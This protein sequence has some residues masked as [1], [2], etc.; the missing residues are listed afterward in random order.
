MKYNPGD[1]YETWLERVRTAELEWA[2]REILR[3]KDVDHVLEQMSQRIVNK[4][5]HPLLAI[6]R[7]PKIVDTGL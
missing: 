2:R 5:L 7:N 1:S 6:L 3:G 4:S